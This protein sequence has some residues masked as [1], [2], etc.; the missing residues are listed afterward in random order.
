[1]YTYYRRDLFMIKLRNGL[2]IILFIM[3][4]LPFSSMLPAVESVTDE[5]VNQILLPT[6]TDDAYE[7]DDSFE[8]A[9]NITLNSKQLRSIYP[10]AD[11]DF[12]A[13][14]LDTFYHITITIDESAGDTRVWLY[15]Y[16]R[17]PLVFDDNDGYGLNATVDFMHLK[18]GVYFIKVEET[19]N[20][21]EIDNYSITVSTTQVTDPYEDDSCSNP[22]HMYFN[23]SIT[24]S[25]NPS[26][27]WDFFEFTLSTPHNITVETFGGP[28]GDTVIDLRTVCDEDATIIGVNDD[29]GDGTAYSKLTFTNL[30]PGTYY[31]KVYGY[32][33]TS[34]V[35]NYSLHLTA[36]S[37]SFYDITGPVI[38]SI[39]HELTEAYGPCAAYIDVLS[40]D[41]YGVSEVKLFYRVNY[42]AWNNY[43][44]WKGSSLH[45]LTT[46]GPF[47]EGDFVEYYLTAEDASSNH[48]ERI[49]NNGG[50]YY[51]FTV[52]NNDFTGPTI[53]N[54]HHS[55]LTP[56][57]TELVT[58]NCT[59]T[60]PNGINSASLIY[61]INGGSWQAVTLSH[62]INDNYLATRGPFA[63]GD[64]VEYYINATDDSS[65]HNIGINN[66]SGLFYSFTIP[67]EDLTPPEITNISHS[68]TAPNEHDIVAF[69]CDVTDAN[70]IQI[71]YIY[72]RVDGGG[73][74]QIAMGYTIGSDTY[75]ISI[76]VFSYLSV[77]EYCIRAYDNSP[78]HNTVL[79]DNGGLYY[80]FT[81]VSSDLTEPVINSISHDPMFPTDVQSINITC[82]AWD[83]SGINSVILHYRLNA[84]TWIE[85][86]MDLISGND[87]IVTFDPFNVGDFIEYYIT[88]TDNSLAENEAV[89]DN[90]GLYYN[91]SIDDVSTTTPVPI[92]YFIPLI[93][94]FSL[95]ILIRKRK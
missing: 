55:P 75:F 46:I 25:I 18:P 35:M 39:G 9:S 81:V 8:T 57:E 6:A 19:G 83:V 2:S 72:Y 44:M 89:N 31:V 21:A 15:D 17:T 45:Y 52:L 3:L 68:P 22:T 42:G 43:S 29:K 85:V 66:N 53:T 60:D 80:S 64:Q 63:Y 5:P 82:Y 84:D 92:T 87:Y 36:F 90:G 20:D 58:F 16:H 56:N 47:L 12:I 28:T 30:A 50:L 93:T 7:D 48:N 51:N 4:L 78:N 70:G 91:F 88:A 79:D 32:F 41:L 38:T 23:S 59:I 95:I 77:V 49:S 13:F 26:G 10:I 37:S 74:T 62:D 61:R 33:E 65:Q 94:M 34:P 54:V 69:S 76:G 14:E 40:H 27:D 73:W 71:V 86:E 1:M 11:P 67:L 24:K